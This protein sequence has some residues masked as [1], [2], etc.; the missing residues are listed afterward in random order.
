MGKQWEVFN[1]LINPEQMITEEITELTRITN[2]MVIDKP[3][4]S[5]I[6]PKFQNFLKIVV[7]VAHNAEFDISFIKTNCK[8]LGLDFNPTFNVSMEFCKSSTS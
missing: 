5:E 1:E 8:R 4:I 2:E 6:M 7:Y 3:L